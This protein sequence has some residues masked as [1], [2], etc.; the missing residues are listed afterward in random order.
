MLEGLIFLQELVCKTKSS[1]GLHTL[2]PQYE[3]PNH[4]NVVAA[5]ISH[6]IPAKP[7]RPLRPKMRTHSIPFQYTHRTLYWCHQTLTHGTNFIFK[8][9]LPHNAK[10]VSIVVMEIYVHL[11]F[12]R[13]GMFRSIGHSSISYGFVISSYIL[14]NHYSSEYDTRIS[15][16]FPATCNHYPIAFTTPTFK[17]K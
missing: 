5:T 12:L 3:E 7:I 4:S 16:S 1:P 9:S 8:T 2:Q 6:H 15:F 17:I 10:G 11:C 14:Q 13:I